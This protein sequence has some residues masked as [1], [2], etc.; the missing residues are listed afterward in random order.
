MFP[1]QRID[2]ILQV[3]GSLI[4]KVEEAEMKVKSFEI[5][6]DPLIRRKVSRMWMKLY[7]FIIKAV[8]D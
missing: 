2:N 7:F 1:I 8:C 3:S 6:K 4:L 5:E